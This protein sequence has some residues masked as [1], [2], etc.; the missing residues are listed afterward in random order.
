MKSVKRPIHQE[1][2]R[3]AVKTAGRN[4]KQIACYR[5]VLF[6]TNCVASIVAFVIVV[7]MS[8]LDIARICLTLITFGNYNNLWKT[9]KK[10]AQII[11]NYFLHASIKIF[12]GKKMSTLR[13]AINKFVFRKLQTFSD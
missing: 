8:L 3:K 1:R 4:P 13:M 10:I 12:T 6:K 11:K 5:S 2:V 7:I 9:F